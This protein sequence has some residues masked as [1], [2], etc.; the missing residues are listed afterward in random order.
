MKRQ[1]AKKKAAI[2]SIIVLV[3]LAIFGIVG[4]NGLQRSEKL[5]N[6]NAVAII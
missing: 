4:L 6:Y 3:V 5:F 1:I 2:I